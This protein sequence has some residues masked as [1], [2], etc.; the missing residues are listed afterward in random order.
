[1]ALGVAAGPDILEF[2]L[3]HPAFL[4]S[5]RASTCSSFDHLVGSDKHR[6]GNSKSNGSR[7]SEIHDEGECA[8]LNDREVADPRSFEDTPDIETDLSLPSNEARAIAHQS[9]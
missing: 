4:F 1:M 9:A 3:P 8:G 7:R 2:S 6:H 5:P